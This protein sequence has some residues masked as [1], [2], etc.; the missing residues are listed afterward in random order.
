[1]FQLIEVMDG[2]I[3][4]KEYIFIRIWHQKGFYFNKTKLI[5]FLLTLRTVSETLK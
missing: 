2:Y 5:K 4:Y 3:F 1:M